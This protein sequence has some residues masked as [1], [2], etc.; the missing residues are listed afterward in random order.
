M[1]RQRLDKAAGD[2]RGVRL[3]GHAGFFRKHM[4]FQ[5]VEQ[6]PFEDADQPKLR[7]VDMRVD[8]TGE[9][10]AASKVEDDCIRPRSANLSEVA[11]G[12]GP[13]VQG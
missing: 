5:P 12:S 11:A 1:H 2:A 8:K 13:R 7:K 9:N 6:L 3:I 4:V 10:V